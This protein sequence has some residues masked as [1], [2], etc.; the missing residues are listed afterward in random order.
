MFGITKSSPSLP[1]AHTQGVK[2]LVVV[3]VVV[4][5][6]AVV[7]TKIAKSRD[8]FRHLSE[9][10]ATDVEFGKKNKKNWLQYTSSMAYKC[11]K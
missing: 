4:V 9:L 8:I 10:S 11:H 6:I 1:R 2:Q 5:A 7:D 3:V